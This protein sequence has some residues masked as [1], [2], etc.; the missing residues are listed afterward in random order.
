MLAGLL[1]LAFYVPGAAWPLSATGAES[2]G[3]PPLVPARQHCVATGLNVAGGIGPDRS[4]STAV[5]LAKLE[6]ATSRRAQSWPVTGTANLSLGKMFGHTFYRIRL[7]GSSLTDDPGAYAESLLRFPLEVTIAGLEMSV[8]SSPQASTAWEVAVGLR[9]SVYDP[10]GKME[11]SDWL[12]DPAGGFN[13]KIAFTRSDSEADVFIVD[14]SG[15]FELLR[16]QSAKIKW[17][18]GYMYQD[19]SYE[20]VGVSGW[21]LDADYERVYFDLFKGVNVLDYRVSYRIPYLGVAASLWP[22]RRLALDARFIV[23]PIVS[24]YDRDDHILRRKW[25]EGGCRGTS[26]AGGVNATWTIISSEGGPRWSLGLGGECVRTD[27]DGEQ[28]QF[29]YGD[30]P[31][32]L[33]DDTGLKK[34]GIDLEIGSRQYRLMIQFG[35]CF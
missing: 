35:A 5:A 34:E 30:D 11:D 21:M 25:A 3:L 1:I 8:R 33:G 32:S 31:G 12:N 16:R 13:G 6:M 9:R 26:F 17:I 2:Y 20:V 10:V 22:S 28:T 18:L 24:A 14:A 19:F 27:T 23:S 4:E 7:S 29:F 15:G